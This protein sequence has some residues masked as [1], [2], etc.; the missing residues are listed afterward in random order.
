MQRTELSDKQLDMVTSYADGAYRVMAEL[1]VD[2]P[3]LDEML[4]DHNV[5]Q[6]PNCHWYTDS[7]HLVVDSDEPDGFCDNC[8][9]YSDTEN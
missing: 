5:E 2:K 8:R 7:C 1:K 6:C 4:L 3:T 9:R